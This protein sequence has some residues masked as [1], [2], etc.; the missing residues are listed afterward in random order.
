MWLIFPGIQLY[1]DSELEVGYFGGK[2][3][4]AGLVQ[5]GEMKDKEW[6]IDYFQKM[7]FSH[8][9]DDVGLLFAEVK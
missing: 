1:L 6:F 4:G 3:Q 8:K 2:P 9:E 5:T 7:D